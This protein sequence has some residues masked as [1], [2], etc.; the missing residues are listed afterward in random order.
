MGLVGGDT[1]ALQLLEAAF[2][3]VFLVGRFFLYPD[4]S[5]TSVVGRPALRLGDQ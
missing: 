5:A 1:A 3:G 4:S 2:V